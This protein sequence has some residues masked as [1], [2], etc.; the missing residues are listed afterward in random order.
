[1]QLQLEDLHRG[2]PRGLPRRARSIPGL[3]SFVTC[4]DLRWEFKD[5]YSVQTVG[6]ANRLGK[7]GSPVYERWQNALLQYRDGKQPKYGA[8]WLTYYPHIMVEWYPH[9]LTVSTLHPD[10][11]AEDA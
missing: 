6:V 5:N 8:I 9:V 7:A 3:G 1:M 10:G 2:L 4:D 11:P